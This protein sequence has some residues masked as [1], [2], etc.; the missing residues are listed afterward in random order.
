ML[1]KCLLTFRGEAIFRTIFLFPMA[2]SFIVTGDEAA[3]RQLRTFE[4][5]L[6]DLRPFW[7]IVARLFRGWMKA[8]FDSEGSFAGRPWAPLSPEYASVV[9]L[10]DT[11]KPNASIS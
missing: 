6:S 5:L 3:E 10:C 9:P 1:S 8:Q 11:R 4:L 7:P 2:I